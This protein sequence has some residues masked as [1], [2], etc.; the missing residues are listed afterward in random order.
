[1]KN[2]NKKFKAIEQIVK[3]GTKVYGNEWVGAGLFE[4]IRKIVD[5]EVEPT[6]QNIQKLLDEARKF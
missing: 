1:M 2:N 4:A 6:A 3:Q 5:D